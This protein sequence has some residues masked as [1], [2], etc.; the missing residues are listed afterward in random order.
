MSRVKKKI[1]RVPLT[2]LCVFAQTVLR[3]A[4]CP[5]SCT[6]YVPTEVHC[7]F[8][9]LT[10]VPG[11]IQPAVEKINL[12]YNS[13][14]LLKESDFAGLSRL[15][16]LLLHS[17][18]IHQVEDK[19]FGDLHVLQVLKMSYNRVRE[20]NKD[21]F[22]GLKSL[23]R[24]HVDHNRIEFIHPEAFYGLTA[25]QLVHLEGNLL[26]QLH[27]DTFV[28][29]RYS[30]IFKTS[31]IRSIHL[32]DNA[33]ST[34][35]ARVFSPC[36]KLES[37]YLHGN[38][39][40]CDCRLEWL[41]KW[42]RKDPGVLKCKRDRKHVRG[43][44]CPICETPAV[45]RGQNIVHLP[46][47][48]LS[49]SKPWILARLKEKNLTLDE[50]DFSTASPGDFIAPIGSLVMNM[51]DQFHNDA[52][53]V[54]TVQ[55][56]SLMEN[57]TVAHSEGVVTLC[58]N[59]A[60]S[61]VC[62]IDYEHIQQLW[63]ILAAY[64]DTP[65]RL[66]RGLMLAKTPEMIYRYTQ[67]NP[68]GDS[69]VFTNV[70]AEIKANPGWLMQ[71]E[72]S[73][74]LDRTTTTFTAL[75]IKYMST[76]HLR[77]DSKVQRK[78]RYSWA[79]I[80]RDNR[81][82]TEHSALVGG[83]IDLKCQVYGHPKPSVEWI[84]PD[85]SKVRAPYSND[86]G[87]IVITDS[88]GLTVRA[89]DTSDTG[90]YH[91]IATNYLDAD[92]LTFRVT[93]LP[94]EVE[95]EDVNGV[96][97]SYSI[98]DD[99]LLDCSS[100]GNPKP[101]VRWILPDHTVLDESYGH[102]RLFQNG[103]LRVQGL[104][105]RDRGF[106]RCLTA[107]HMGV[108]L[109]TS[110]VML[111]GERRK[112][113]EAES[114]GDEFD[115]NFEESVESV[116]T[117]LPSSRSFS[118]QES[119]TVTADRP[120]PR[121]RA[122]RK[123]VSSGIIQR[124][125]GSTSN[126]RAWGSRRTFDKSS[127]KADPK[128]WEEMLTKT[129]KGR[130]EDVKDDTVITLKSGLT[131]DEHMGS[132]DDLSEGELII[133]PDET[134][135]T[136]SQ[137]D[138][139][140][141]LSTASLVEPGSG[142]TTSSLV[143]QF[144]VT[145]HHS[146]TPN[147]NNPYILESKTER[148]PNLP[149]TLKMEMTNST[150]EM[151][152]I[153]SGDSE[154]TATGKMTLFVSQYP[155]GT[156]M[157]NGPGP[158]AEPVVHTSSGPNGHTTFTALTTTE[159]VA[160]EIMFHTTQ[161]I[162]SPGLPAG[163]TIISHQEIHIIPALKQR[164]GRR[165]SFPGR[166]RIIK[167]NK[168]TD[169]SAYL[170]KL[171]KPPGVERPDSRDPSRYTTERPATAALS[172]SL[173]TSTSFPASARASTPDMNVKGITMQPSTIGP[174]STTRSNDF[175][176][177]AGCPDTYISQAP[178]EVGKSS[179]RMDRI[180][181]STKAS[182]PSKVIRG[183][184]PWQKLF[185]TKDHKELPNR[186]RKPVKPTPTGESTTAVKTTSTAAPAR[187]P[188]LP[189]AESLISPITIRPR[190][191]D[192]NT[193]AQP[194]ETLPED[195][196]GS[197]STPEPNAESRFRKL[198]PAVPPLSFN[199]RTFVSQSPTI[200]PSF[201]SQAHT[202]TAKAS[203]TTQTIAFP[204]TIQPV[205]EK[206]F[207]ASS[208]SSGSISG[209]GGYSKDVVYR[210]GG[211]RRPVWPPRRNGF[212]RRRPGKSFTTATPRTT[213]KTTTQSSITSVAITST[214]RMIPSSVT[215]L[216]S[217]PQ[218]TL[219]RV[220][221]PVKS[222][223]TTTARSSG[224]ETTTYPN[225]E[226]WKDLSA[227]TTSP[228]KVSTTTTWSRTTARPT[229]LDKNTPTSK[230][231][232]TQ[233]QT[234][235]AVSRIRSTANTFSTDT[236]R[237]IP[238]G[239]EPQYPTR[240]TPIKK[241]RPPSFPE[242]NTQ[243]GIG[244]GGNMELPRP[245]AAETSKHRGIYG[246]RDR[247]ATFTILREER[248]N[249]STPSP[250][251]IHNSV[252]AGYDLL[253]GQETSTP[254]TINSVSSALET[255]SK[256]K[257]VGGNAAQ[258][259]VL[260]NSD[261]FLP[262]VADGFPEPNI[263]WKRFSSITG[264]ELCS[265]LTLTI[266]GK[267]GKF[268]VFSNGTLSIQ[269]T[270]MKDRG[271][272]LCLAQNDFGSDKLLVTLSVV[273]YP[274]R[275]LEPKVREINSHPGNTIEIK[276]RAE[277][278]PVP[279]IS[280]ILANRTQV[281]GYS[282]DRERVT[283]TPDGTL[284]IHQVSAYDR[285][286]YKCIAS[287]PAG[288]DTV[289]VR[290]HVV[291]APPGILEEKRQYVIGEAG[292]SVSLPCSAQ[293]SP[294]PTVHWV[295][296]D[297]TV[298][299]PL[300]DIR[301]NV[302]LLANGTLLLKDL[303]DSEGGT[304]ECIATSSTGSERRVVTL[305]VKQTALV[306]RIVEASQRWT[307]IGYGQQLLLNCSAVG[308]PKPVI[309]W[310]LPSKVVV[311]R[312]HRMGARIH[313]LDNGT[314]TIS[315]LSEKDAG[316]YLCIARNK[317]GDD[318][319]LMKVSVSMKPAKIETKLFD[320]KRVPYGD[321]LKVDCRASG[322]PVPEISWGLPDGTLVNSALQADDGKGHT[323]RYVLFN[324]GT[325]Y[326]NNVGMEEEGDYTCYAENTVGKDEMHVHITVVMAAPRIRTPGHT[327]VK[328]KAGGKVRFDCEPVGEP[329]PKVLW[330]LPSQDIIAASNE[331]YL[332]H[333]NGSLDIRN[334]KLT[335]AGEYVCV[336]RNAAGEDRKVYRLDIDDNPPIINGYHTNRTVVK[337]SA[338]K[339]S[340]KM[341]D[342][343]AEGN[344][345][346]QITWIMPDNIFITAPYFGSRINIHENGT[347]E[348][349]NV[350]PTDTAE[351]ICMAR[352]DGGEAVMVVQLQVTSMLRRP[353]FKNPLNERVVTR[354]GK[355]TVLNCSADGQ[356]VP[357]IT[358]LL[359]DGTRVT[360]TSR[361]AQYQ[362]GN[363]GVFILYSATKEDAG[364]YRCAAKNSVGYIEK[365]IVL[366]VGQKPYILTRPKGI[367]RSMSGEPLYLHCLADG[368]PRPQVHWTL[369]GGAVLSHPQVSGR[370][371]L[372]E[373]GTLIVRDSTLHDRGNYLCRAKNDAGEDLLMVPVTV[374]TYPPRI[375][376]GPPQTLRA[377]PGLPVQLSCAAVGLPRPEISWELPDRSVLS[378]TGTGQTTGNKRLHPQ[379]T[380]IIQ[381]P[382]VSDSGTYKCVAKNHFGA[383]SRVAYV[384]VL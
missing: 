202:T 350:R 184:I 273:A 177:S 336:A 200:P 270:N 275:I 80:K 170:N 173:I 149:M 242:R 66:Q 366:E 193:E 342:C 280:W 364:K 347:L 341:I 71:D 134:Q 166:R 136:L 95:E 13:L 146:V 290:L 92:V 72:V 189:T 206:T 340:R 326:F 331:R 252:S 198:T 196:S 98:G 359:P 367:I 245:E 124:R 213:V 63:R 271:Q 383:D 291:A 89:A 302:S 87:R 286:H 21:T 361:G 17:N 265:F 229:T 127:R 380:L 247:G 94:P 105:Q 107:N 278:R 289:S 55:R 178:R 141:V 266:K 338:A 303:S 318:L 371:M 323:R 52:S 257:I 88:G 316:D 102:R 306:P 234:S 214:V 263:I 45:S 179:S 354:L 101:S 54:C 246:P 59:V 128:K 86:D 311:D 296:L 365:L 255:G 356:P 209:S 46:L 224:D 319:Q 153:F 90:L 362:L 284:V 207:E 18:T 61:L 6:C 251:K 334:I 187:V 222:T 322:T 301:A 312:W 2:L 181:A 299:R 320:K 250:Y 11:H 156:S 83:L 7:T 154:D 168:I 73:L 384:H 9:Y 152:L 355:T 82:E 258:Y 32:S 230:P 155:N 3:G 382:T 126:W 112:V 53:L 238:P 41:V 297:G 241:V 68:A 339:Y 337:D 259:T 197:S 29:M 300:Q 67:K 248:G 348:I 288:V 220:A 28:T 281:R 15:E 335:D 75:H 25:L 253:E 293:G 352:N 282:S 47:D 44:H 244:D 239:K 310:K 287:N 129:Q 160:G 172:P 4:A 216:L 115:S 137:T 14:T 308:E 305:S 108:D 30:Q 163:S 351:F 40:S 10:V 243:S 111:L 138:A 298:I 114:S 370:Y 357:E 19:A 33:M 162:K 314:L 188:Q 22:F 100:A 77:E 169:I 363:D 227:L 64:S 307:E 203:A 165:R 321:D 150:S 349:R 269:N 218:Y 268:E 329:K 345:P 158:R 199:T 292:Q 304:Y 328:V 274:S 186:L 236:Y 330:M 117:E 91:C 109:L 205:V 381:R 39:W 379:G 279:L 5:A 157:L 272:Y 264:K 194:T 256:P 358:W 70:E 283:V 23:L 123:R 325:L 12:G 324:N 294:Q 50:G 309:L 147:S 346:P 79:M 60:S 74:Q 369:P 228:S 185:G 148:P 378:S 135:S 368:S 210:R 139:T 58:A 49:C 125:R 8:R 122:S 249:A 34:L 110:Q 332:M 285:G 182:T 315:S 96:R 84:L 142:G 69:E 113:L 161:K 204:P 212:R 375:T 180:T 51:T 226:D 344:P 145:H 343:K 16:L 106:Y 233:T 215:M 130:T 327:Y 26:Q 120:F 190:V 295:L 373:N 262:C 85:G 118:G 225:A 99:L 192:E 48:A 195:F 183:K 221:E 116:I 62:N 36:T 175:I 57:L 377:L 131:K 353:I 174:L 313:I 376:S 260:S 219:F 276:C 267:M 360:G 42:A 1:S 143:P 231:L 235:P 97:L 76:V 374:V 35:P 103:S 140:P 208:S 121:H 217:K 81:T 31:S 43:A 133:M 104:T 171:K 240:R 65:M 372:L 201:P 317:M 223:R 176:T 78:D 24:L 144:R 277:G 93:V 56:P 20:I 38:P 37:V 232:K 333:V 164:P 237:G 151:Q 191:T 27:P 211:S 119:T 254:H 261:A 167:P 132:G 159:Q